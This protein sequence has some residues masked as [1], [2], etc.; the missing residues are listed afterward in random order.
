MA[1]DLSHLAQNS[2]WATNQHSGNRPSDPAVAHTAPG[3]PSPS[4]D[5]ADVSPQPFVQPV[6]HQRSVVTDGQDAGLSGGRPVLKMGQ[7]NDMGGGGAPR[8]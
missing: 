8:A 4:V 2:L 3:T 7:W 1:Q 5:E 6:D